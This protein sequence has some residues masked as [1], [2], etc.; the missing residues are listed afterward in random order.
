MKGF[1]KVRRLLI[2]QW[3]YIEISQ[4]LNVSYSDMWEICILKP[5]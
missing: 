2:I 1:L 4:D 3:K 5:F